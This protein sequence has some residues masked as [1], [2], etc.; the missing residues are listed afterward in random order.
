[1]NIRWI[2]RMASCGLL[3]ASAGLGA[4]QQVPKTWDDA[5]VAALEVP[6]VNRAYS[7]VH[8]SSADYYRLPVRQV[9]KS[10][11]IYASGKEP[12]GYIDWLMQRE[13]VIVF[14]PAKL[15]TEADWI[16]AGEL[17]FDVPI[18]ATPGCS[19]KSRPCWRI[20]M[21]PPISSPGLRQRRPTDRR[22]RLVAARPI[23]GSVPN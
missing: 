3:L 13:P 8:I 11:P 15:K 12:P 6:L 22:S 2:T 9:F 20:N 21:T 23:P 5:A 10:Y 4:P 14:D 16:R 17:V 18:T 19:M 7:P 1:M